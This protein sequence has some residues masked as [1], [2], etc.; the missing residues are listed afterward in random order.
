MVKDKINYRAQGPRTLLT[1]QT[2]Q[3]RANDGGLRIGEMERDGIVAHGASCFLNSSLME[4]GDS[5]LVAVCNKTG[6]IAIMNQ[7]QNLFLSPL[8]DGPLKFEGDLN[9][10]SIN[11]EKISKYG[12]DFSII[13]VPYTF[14]LLIQEL[15]TM[16]VQLR[17]ITEDNIN[18]L[19][20]MTF[21]K[22]INILMDDKRDDDDNTYENDVPLK[23]MIKQNS[24]SLEGQYKTENQTP[25]SN[26][27]SDYSSYSDFDLD[28][29]PDYGPSPV[30]S[31][32]QETSEG[33][34]GGRLIIGE[35][36]PNLVTDDNDN[37][38]TIT[39]TNANDTNS[40]N[41]LLAS[42]IERYP[43]VEENTKETQEKEDGTMP[44]NE[45]NSIK[46]PANKMESLGDLSGGIKIVK[47][48]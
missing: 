20:S 24:D 27:S 34:N 2:V 43:V 4:R 3:G 12:S 37:T 36:V 8:L 14:K 7:S 10:N 28:A 39:T 44:E 35:T 41:D 1:R 15:T 40:A 9:S 45:D 30:E 6:M 38:T 32:S 23:Q 13:K 25:V 19:Q 16:N 17:I 22:N 47:N 11:V 18:Q 26:E 33:L 29:S 46:K 5:Y 48:K 21:S 31:A 42:F